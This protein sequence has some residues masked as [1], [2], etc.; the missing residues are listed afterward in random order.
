[1]LTIRQGQMDAFDR[2]T[3]NAFENEMV[4]H[5]KDFAPGIS[6]AAGEPALRRLIRSGIERSMRFGMTNRGPVRLYLE[7]MVLLGHNYDSDPL[8]PWAG[9]ILNG[10]ITPD[11]MQH[12]ERLYERAIR[13]AKDVSGPDNEFLLQ[14]LGKFQQ[15]NAEDYA[16]PIG[17]FEGVTGRLLLEFY[18][19]KYEA[20]GPAVV[21]EI[22]RRGPDLAAR[23]GVGTNLGNLLFVVLPFLVGAGFLTDPLY[24][25]ID[26][27]LNDPRLIDPTKRAARLLSRCKTYLSEVLET[28]REGEPHGHL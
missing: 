8:L 25:W 19:Q 3:F 5:L 18:P 23:N 10:R 1:V 7:L 11:Q 27:T 14:A 13:H 16:V 17:Q 9:E 22:I 15:A 6:R 2:A 4:G 21:R 28:P 26:G 12:A 24:A 20:A